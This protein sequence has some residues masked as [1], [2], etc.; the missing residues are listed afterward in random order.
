MYGPD[1]CTNVEMWR[2]FK[3]T[4]KRDEIFLATKCGYELEPC[5]ESMKKGFALNG[6]PDFIRKAIDLSLEKLATDHIDLWY[7]HR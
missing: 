1:R 3:R 6:N 7:L 4:G 5:E 2:R